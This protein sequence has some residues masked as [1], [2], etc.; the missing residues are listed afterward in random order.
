M[1]NTESHER[2]YDVARVV[3]PWEHL[4]YLV[5]SVGALEQIA[6]I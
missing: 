2:R 6:K 3:R 4:V 1:I 5:S